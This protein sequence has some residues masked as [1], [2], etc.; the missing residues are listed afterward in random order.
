MLVRLVLS[1]LSSDRQYL[2]ILFQGLNLTVFDV[3]TC[4][5]ENIACIMI[6]ITCVA[7]LSYVRKDKTVYFIHTGSGVY[8][9]STEQGGEIT[10][11]LQRAAQGKLNKNRRPTA[12]R[13]KYTSLDL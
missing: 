6:F 4:T 1:E 9:F 8:A 11:A 2:S 7:L 10:E 13:S 12:Q 5:L 3:Q